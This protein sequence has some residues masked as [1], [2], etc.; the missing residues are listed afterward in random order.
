MRECWEG[1]SYCHGWSATPTRDLLVHTLGSTPAEPGYDRVRVAPRLG[2]LAWARGAVPSPHGLVSVAVEGDRVMVD[3][4]VP[5][6]LSHPGGA[7]T[8]HPEG[9]TETRLRV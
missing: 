5:V 6:E 3:S 8:H 1:G 4:P 2:G 7:V 9:S